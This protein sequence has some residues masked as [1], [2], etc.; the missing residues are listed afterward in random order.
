MTS[1]A[2]AKKY[3][4]FLK[5]YSVPKEDVTASITNTRIPSKPT[6]P[7]R[8]FG[9][10]YNIPDDKYEEFLTVYTKFCIDD[11]NAEYLTEKQREKDCPILIDMDLKYDYSVDRRIHTKGRSI[12]DP[13]IWNH[14]SWS[15]RAFIA[16]LRPLAG[17]DG[18]G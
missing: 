18:G 10:K 9:G 8:V 17:S 6:D 14:V 2:N 3:Q 7:E 11:G 13:I 15:G 16:Y 1:A 4:D 5:A 12:T